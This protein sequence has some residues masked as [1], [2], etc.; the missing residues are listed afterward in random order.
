M[1]NNCLYTNFEI[2]KLAKIRYKDKYDYSLIE[3]KTTTTKIKI[4]CP[5]HGVFEQLPEKFL[6][7]CGCPICDFVDKAN[8][9]HGTRFDY[10]LIDFVNKTTDVKIICHKHGEFFQSPQEHLKRKIPCDKC[11]D[12][13]NAITPEKFIKRANNIHQNRYD[14]SKVNYVSRLFSVTI[15][16]QIHGEFEQLPANH[17]VGNGCP[18]C[19]KFASNIIIKDILDNFNKDGK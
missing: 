7:G 4:V 12:E 1:G 16:C 10:S 11:L 8:K 15:I 18:K 2:I 13:E 9:K 17:L 6:I 19:G 14:Y 5:I 3:Y